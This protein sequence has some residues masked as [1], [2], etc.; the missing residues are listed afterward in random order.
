VNSLARFLDHPSRPPETLR[1]HELQ[2]F[3]FAVASA[4]DLVRPSEWLPEVFGG[5]EAGFEA[6]EEAQAILPELM[7]L[8]NAVNA[9]V[10]SEPV[11]L[12]PD[13]RFRRKV[14]I[15]FDDGAPMSLWSRGFLRGHQWLE[16]DW[17]PVPDEFDQE[18]AMVLMTLSFFASRRL[19]EAYVKELGRSDLEEAA[20]LFR[21]AF[22]DA[23]TEYA[24]PFRH[25]GDTF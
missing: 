3:L 12:P 16:E 2:G 6:L 10:T 13:C 9:S 23:L 19:A 24:G 5:R 20:M 14:L 22:P 11:T 21:R 7:A 1:Y 18:F 15:N 17:D 4:P 8:Y 25:M